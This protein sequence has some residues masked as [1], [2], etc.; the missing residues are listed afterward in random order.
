MP[1]GF[2]LNHSGTVLVSGQIFIMHANDLFFSCH[3][4]CVHL[5]VPEYQSDFSFEKEMDKSAVRL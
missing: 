5:H 2:A 4:V 3:G 1:D